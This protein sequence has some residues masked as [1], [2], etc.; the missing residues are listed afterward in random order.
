MM[1]DAGEELPISIPKAPVKED[2]VL[3]E[4]TED[5]KPTTMVFDA[6]AVFDDDEDEDDLVDDDKG[7]K[8]E[9]AESAASREVE[10]EQIFQTLLEVHKKEIDLYV[11]SKSKLKEGKDFAIRCV[12]AQCP[13]GM[14]AVLQ[15]R[16]G[17]VCLARAVM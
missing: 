11:K 12:W 13:T 4:R 2:V 1:M 15:N 9:T 7:V 10:R 16:K 14:K 6:M 17:S 3:V 5:E 8:S